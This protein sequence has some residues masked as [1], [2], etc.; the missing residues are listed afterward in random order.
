MSDESK[1]L[2]LG[3]SIGVGVSAAAAGIILALRSGKLPK[4]GPKRNVL[5]LV[6]PVPEDVVISQAVPLTPV[7]ELFYNK[8][9][10]TDNEL[11][12]HGLYKGKLSLD[13]YD[14]L[15]DKPDGNY[16][17]VCGINPTPLYRPKR[18]PAQL[19]PPVRS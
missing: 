11:F 19:P 4:G 8:F 10:L 1:A 2:K 15:K 16:V 13:T 5:D 3:I 12:A 6:S 14:R 9:G 18:L 7:R 17:V